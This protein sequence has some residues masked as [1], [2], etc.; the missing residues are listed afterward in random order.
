MSDFNSS[1]PVRTEAN[2]DVAAKLVDGTITS[3]TLAIDASGLIGAKAYD[4]AGTALTSQANGGQR[5][6]DVGIDVAGVQIDPRQIRALTAGDSVTAVQGTSPWIGKDQSDGPVAPGTV[7]SFSSLAGGQFNTVLPT[8]TNTQQVA[9]QVD[10]SGRII[11]S[12]LTSAS[13]ITVSNLPT[14]VDTNYGTVGSSTIRTAAQIGNATGAADFNAGATGAQ[15]L[16][17]TGNQGTPNTAGNAWPTYLTIG[18][19]A[20]GPTNPIFVSSS[21]V[22]GVSIDN[23]NTDS[24]LAAN[25]SNNHDYTVTAAKTFYTKQFWASGSGKLKVEVQYETAAASGIFN[26]FWV[27]FNSTANPNILIPVPTS[28]TQVT[29]ARLR[30][31]RTNLDKQSQDVYSTISG[32]EQ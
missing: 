16:R 28:K 10:S 25:A 30:I 1:L 11:I 19:V 9:L 26:S 17:V 8:V 24:A 22:A 2:G 18:G 5:A 3:Q 29:G 14:T 21:D 6:L 23:Y 31:I 12:P 4:G 20:N 32:T 27:G 13:T 7:A 15:T